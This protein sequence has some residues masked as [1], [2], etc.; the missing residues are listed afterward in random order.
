[1]RPTLLATLALLLAACQA[2][3]PKTEPA[4]H[5]AA[6]KYHGRAGGDGKLHV[7]FFDVGQGDAALVISPSGHS[8][9]I[10]GGPLE[11]AEFVIQRLSQLL[12]GPLDLAVLTHPQINHLGGFEEILPR[13][14]VKRFMDP[15]IAP[16]NTAAQ[17]ADLRAW[18]A[19]NGVEVFAPTPDP[20]KPQLP[21]E[22]GIGGGATLSVYW[23]RRPV[24]PFLEA[25]ERGTEP[26]SMVTRVSWGTTS[27][28]FMSDAPIVTEQLLLGKPFKLESTVLKVGAH[29]GE[30]SGLPSFLRLVSPLAAVISVG[31]GNTVKAP[32]RVTQERLVNV[33]ARI[34]RT[35]LDGEI[36]LVADAQSAHLSTERV[37][38]GD[39]SGR[40]HLLSRPT[41]VAT[42]AARSALELARGDTRPAARA[43]QPARAPARTEP[44]ASPRPAARTP[45]PVVAAPKAAPVRPPPV[46][47]APAEA[48]PPRRR[49]PVAAAPAAEEVESPRPRPARSEPAGPFV[50][51]QKG[52]VFHHPSC[53]WAKKIHKDN[54]VQFASFAEASRTR[55]PHA[56][57]V[58]P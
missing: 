20:Q 28:L 8:V 10:D 32:S 14:G 47:E 35:D 25:P 42:E 56:E 52:E 45:S 26:N 38:A 30:S 2:D 11:S 1:M 41:A 7:Y 21:V 54:V 37:A 5:A 18:M 12:A 16:I 51:S 39:S 46:E 4:P 24:D 53:R 55:R 13:V 43:P 44:D 17:Y 29:G 49:P 33:G 6:L 48:P 57:C 34:F 3:R 27:V 40:V 50:A 36:H 15:E 31:A 58:E 23:P 19:E 22:I 9:L